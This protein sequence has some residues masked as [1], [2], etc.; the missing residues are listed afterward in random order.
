M[1]TPLAI[2]AVAALTALASIKAK[3]SPN[4]T[5]TPEDHLGENVLWVLK[6]GGKSKPVGP[7]GGE[8]TFG[9]HGSY[10]LVGEATVDEVF[11][12]VQRDLLSVPRSR[13]DRIRVQSK[14]EL[15]PKL[16]E[17]FWSDHPP[18]DHSKKP[19]EELLELSMLGGDLVPD[20]D[21]DWGAN[22]PVFFHERWG[23]RDGNIFDPHS[24]GLILAMAIRDGKQT[25]RVAV[26][27]KLGNNRRMIRSALLQKAVPGF[28]KHGSKMDPDVLL[29]FA[30]EY[31]HAFPYMVNRLGLKVPVIK[32]MSETQ[33]LVRMASN[34]RLVDPDR[35]R[36]GPSVLLEL[37][38][39]LTRELNRKAGSAAQ[40]SPA[41]ELLRRGN[42]YLP[43]VL[44]RGGRFD[45]TGKDKAA[46]MAYWGSDLLN[47]EF[48]ETRTDTDLF[49]TALVPLED[50]KSLLV[51]EMIRA[52]ALPE[53]SRL[54]SVVRSKQE[55]GTLDVMELG[56]SLYYMRHSEHMEHT[57]VILQDEY[58]LRGNPDSELCLFDEKARSR[59]SRSI[60]D[61]WTVA[62]FILELEKE[63]RSTVWVT[64]P[65]YRLNRLMG[66][67]VRNHRGEYPERHQDRLRL[68]KKYIHAFPH[69]TNI[70]G[71]KVL[72]DY[73][74]E[75]WTTD[76][77]RELEV[78]LNKG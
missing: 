25:V 74:G 37:D 11:K 9:L 64:T 39:I 44:E 59:Q 57:P 76:L 50:L 43:W 66:R 24:A 73:K 27:V 77:A 1:S 5:F 45:P 75:R 33:P 18:D 3:G 68:L 4:K 28:G 12:V 6:R 72:V 14:E 17:H 15:E 2:G 19:L 46:L 21:T 58:D 55:K 47:L 67:T 26:P 23:T 51:H 34:P 78:E 8:P 38:R 70:F 69:T 16:R 49:V 52:G 36:P 53:A 71:R 22:F 42:P 56:S 7:Y 31:P 54:E 65:G 63:G 20:D 32:V 29:R 13:L 40:A 60:V 41:M 10:V 61:P 30:Q 35:A 62:A 48:D